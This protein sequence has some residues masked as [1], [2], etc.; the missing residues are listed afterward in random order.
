VVTPILQLSLVFRVFLSSWLNREYEVLNAGVI[1]GA[2][3]AIVGSVLVSLDTD[4]A[5]SALALPD[6][7]ASALR[8]RLAGS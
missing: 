3:A 1:V 5:V 7:I 8:F 6:V 2:T 4:F